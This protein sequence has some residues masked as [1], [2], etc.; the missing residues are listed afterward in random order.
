M[1]IGGMVLFSDFVRIARRSRSGLGGLGSS[2]LPQDKNKPY[3]AILL[4]LKS[5][6]SD[7]FEE[8]IRLGVKGF[9]FNHADGKDLV[10]AIKK[11]KEGGLDL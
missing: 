7:C 1:N 2:C 3:F 5:Q 6:Y 10:K 4:L 11:L 8:Y 9:V